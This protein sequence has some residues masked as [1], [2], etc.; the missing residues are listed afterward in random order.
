[1]DKEQAITILQDFNDL[2]LIE[3]QLLTYC[4]ISKD[5]RIKRGPIQKHIAMSLDMTINPRYY[6]LFDKVITKLQI[7]KIKIQGKAHYKG[8]SLK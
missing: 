2:K 6:S 5:T 1:M 8:L 7:K 4:T 3:K